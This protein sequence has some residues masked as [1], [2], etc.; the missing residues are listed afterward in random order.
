MHQ[1]LEIL[2]L[3]VVV[4]HLGFM[5]LEMVLWTRPLGRRIFRLSED[6]ARVTQALAANQGL[7]NGFLAV[8]LAWGWWSDSL[9]L[10]FFFLGC[11][12][13]AGVF[14]A[15]SVNRRIFWVQGLPAMLALILLF[16]V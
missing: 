1:A 6:K 10:Q 15:L 8:G 16:Q 7:Y 2:L 3:L 5:W 11:V 4:L 14:G 9:Q 13:L 12:L